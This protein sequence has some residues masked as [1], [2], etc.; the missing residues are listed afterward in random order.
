VTLDEALAEL[1]IDRDAGV[2]QARRAYLKLLKL[3]KPETDA[4][5]FMRLREAYELA[6]ERLGARDELF[7]AIAIARTGA[8]PVLH[9]PEPVSFVHEPASDVQ[10][11][12]EPAAEAHGPAADVPRPPADDTHSPHPVDE[13]AGEPAEATAENEEPPPEPDPFEPLD[14][15]L[16][17][18]L[19]RVG[20]HTQAAELLARFLDAAA[21]HTE[22][23]PPPVASTLQ[24]LVTL[25]VEGA[26][27]A[28]GALHAS[29]SGWLA[30]S[31]QEVRVIRGDAAVRW[32]LLRELASL[33]SAFPRAAR[34]AIGRAMLAG[35][36]GK[37]NKD[38]VSLHAQQPAVAR[39]A[40]KELRSK[41]PFLA[42]AL[43]DVLDPPIVKPSAH[44]P[45]PPQRS[46]RGGWALATVLIAALRL[47]AF[48][49]R[50]TPTVPSYGNDRYG[51]PSQWSSH[52]IDV[53]TSSG[54]YAP[55]RKP[56]AGDLRGRVLERAESTRVHAWYMMGVDAGRRRID[57]TKETADVDAVA[58][59][60]EREDCKAARAAMTKLEA[61]TRVD[62]TEDEL[63]RV[64]VETFARTL[65]A[66]CAAQS[67]GAA[68]AGARASRRDATLDAGR[69]GGTEKP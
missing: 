27:A 47:I 1:G 17:D 10:D 34:S 18:A 59:A 41:A 4:Q 13:P 31:G 37:A 32:T 11:P 51:S 44:A 24:L 52:P 54:G 7:R 29:L 60:V 25:H 26:V 61:R 58:S 56:A 38:L 64:E 19:L 57:Y 3:R 5:G 69:R 53:S 66:Y 42:A 2:D 45:A 62:V 46:W 8:E 6:K 36:L 20:E 16:L 68:D 35:D 67:K 55:L 39:S 48:G 28:A 33:S 63:G 65:E 12:V 14:E 23:P 21:Q 50:S 9:T 22:G 15:E 43:A 49:S 40:A 30:A